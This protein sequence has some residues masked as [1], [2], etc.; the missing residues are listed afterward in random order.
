MTNAGG[1]GQNDDDCE[2]MGEGTSTCKQ[3]STLEAAVVSVVAII[4]A[5]VLRIVQAEWEQRHH[6]ITIIIQT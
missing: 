2:T 3:Q 5:T 1:E 4:S 6:T